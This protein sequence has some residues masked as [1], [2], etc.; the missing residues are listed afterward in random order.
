MHLVITEEYDRE[1]NVL[2][3]EAKIVY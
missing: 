2:E 3:G 1:I